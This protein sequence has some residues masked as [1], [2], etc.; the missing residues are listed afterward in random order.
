MIKKLA[1][2]TLAAGLLV[3]STVSAAEPLQASKQEPSAPSQLTSVAYTTVFL[4]G[5]QV[6]F[7]VKALDNYFNSNYYQRIAWTSNDKE[8]SVL[9][10]N[11]LSVI[12]AK[13]TGESYQV[14]S[15]EPFNSVKDK[16]ESGQKVYGWALALN[17]VWYPT[18][19]ATLYY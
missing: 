12:V 4:Y 18:M 8:P 7:E 9:N 19:P 6:Y 14:N 1:A 13:K 3:P 5:H 15:Y 17:G 11:I 10:N 2:L 16:I